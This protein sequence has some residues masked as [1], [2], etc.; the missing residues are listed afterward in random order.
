MKPITKTALAL[1]LGG[2]VLASSV[3]ASS[4]RSWRPWA[5]AGA[6]F[7]AG[8]AIGAAAANANAYYYGPGYYYAPGPYAYDGYA[9]DPGPTYV[10]PA[11]SYRYGYG[12]RGCVQD[13][14]Y[15]RISRCD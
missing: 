14:G 4:A 15:G 13:E 7:V 6:G 11:Y 12:Y 3:T 9:Y 5:A 1:A 8:A 10:A 2:A